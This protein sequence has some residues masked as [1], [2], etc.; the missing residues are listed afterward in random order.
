MVSSLA[1][2]SIFRSLLSINPCKL[3]PKISPIDIKDLPSISGVYFVIRDTQVIYIGKS[4]NINQRWCKYPHHIESRMSE[5]D[6][7]TFIGVHITD[8]NLAE[9]L[10]IEYYEPI[11]N[12]Q[13]VVGIPT[14]KKEFTL[15]DIA[16]AF[17]MGYVKGV[18][19]GTRINRAVSNTD[20]LHQINNRVSNIDIGLQMD[21]DPVKIMHL[22]AVTENF[23]DVE[24]LITQASDDEFESSK[25]DLVIKCPYC[26]SPD[27]KKNGL[28]KYREISKQRYQCSNCKK[29]FTLDKMK[30]RF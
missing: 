16:D 21:E 4:R 23:S 11:L 3:S 1:K 5:S 15:S 9:Q 18:T 30:I 19:Q 12:R 14:E 13:Y 20:L 29:S 8:L 7:I 6:F 25:K 10:L 28:T 24:G 26:Q 22:K 2:K 27:I 17:Y